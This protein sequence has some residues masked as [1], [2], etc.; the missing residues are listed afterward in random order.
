MSK[1]KDYLI[2]Q[3]D[4]GAEDVFVEYEDG[5]HSYGP[6]QNTPAQS[7]GT[8]LDMYGDLSLDDWF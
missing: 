7:T 2:G 1:Y 5:D 4:S 6:D 8:E 3:E